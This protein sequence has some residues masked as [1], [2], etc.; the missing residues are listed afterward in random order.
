MLTLLDLSF[1]VLI[2]TIPTSLTCGASQPFNINLSYNRLDRPILLVLLQQEPQNLWWYLGSTF[3]QKQI[4]RSD[5]A[6]SA[7]AL[8]I[9][10]NLSQIGGRRER[11]AS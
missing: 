4:V 8:V 11:G 9:G 1:G 10:A 5:G 7:E 6:R 3:D 2:G